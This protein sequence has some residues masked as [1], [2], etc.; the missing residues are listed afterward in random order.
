MNWNPRLS[1]SFESHS[2][3][4]QIEAD[5]LSCSSFGG[6]KVRVALMFHDDGHRFHLDRSCDWRELNQAC[7]SNPLWFRSTWLSGN[8]I[9]N[10]FPFSEEKS[11][12]FALVEMNGTFR[13]HFGFMTSQPIFDWL[14]KCSEII[15]QFSLV[16][17]PVSWTHISDLTNFCSVTISLDSVVHQNRRIYSSM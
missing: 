12:L 5:S 15:F 10:L 17:E 3:L 2:R 8:L 13:L 4:Y 6:A 7:V 9:W 1:I 14:Q 11:L 16:L